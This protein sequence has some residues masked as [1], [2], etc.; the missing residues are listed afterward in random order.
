VPSK[1]LEGNNAPGLAGLLPAH[2]DKL[3]LAL[4]AAAFL[5]LFLPTYSRLADTIWQS[6]EQGHGPIILAVSAWLLFQKRHALAALPTTT[7]ASWGGWA[8][9]GTGM[10]F[11]VFGH[12][13]GIISME[14]F[15]QILFLGGVILLYK[16]PAGLRLCWFSLFFLIFMIPLPGPLVA[17]VTT[18]LKSAVSAVSAS[19][20]YALG[21]PI[22]RS[23][24]ILTIGPYQLLVADA[25]AGLNSMFTLEALVLLYINLMKY[26][27]AARNIFLAVAAIPISFLS[28]IVRVII[29]VLV[30]YYFGDEAGQGFIHGFAGMVLFIVA[31][32]LTIMLDSVYGVVSKAWSKRK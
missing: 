18:P 31:L 13:Q 7:Q 12:S 19:I 28:N 23:G 26:T 25:C 5:V 27:S 6:D 3:L 21:Y 30:T 22:G 14:V 4:L 17:A 1:P 20:M 16:G 29:L 24:V 15:Y 8:M 2:A 10:L 11:F 32:T 9:L